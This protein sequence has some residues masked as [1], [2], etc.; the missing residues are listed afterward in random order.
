MLEQPVHLLNSELHGEELV[1][2][3]EGGRGPAAVAGH[4]G[5]D[6]VDL[7]VDLVHNLVVGLELVELLE[8]IRGEDVDGQH[9]LHQH[10]DGPAR[11]LDLHSRS[12]MNEQENKSNR[13]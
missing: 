10:V 11:G 12:T 2:E 4:P 3:A 13:G 9:L 7:V 6:V 8:V 1:E 5:L